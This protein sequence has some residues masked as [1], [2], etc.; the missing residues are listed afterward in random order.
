MNNVPDFSN[1]MSYHYVLLRAAYPEVHVFNQTRYVTVNDRKVTY[2]NN[3]ILSPNLTP[4]KLT[5]SLSGGE[6]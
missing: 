5:D 6:Y 1:K 3:E 2:R 4:V